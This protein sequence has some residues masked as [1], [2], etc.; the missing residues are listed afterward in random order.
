MLPF[1]E[2]SPTYD[3]QQVQRLVGQG[4]LSYKISSAAMMGGKELFIDR[5]AIVD[6]VLS[7][8]RDHFYKTMEAELFPGLWQDVYHLRV[9]GVELYIKL[10][11]DEDGRAVVIQFKRR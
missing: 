5:H 9:G 6:V 4:P 8:E 2:R 11:I 1:Y 7:L 3:L 10:Q